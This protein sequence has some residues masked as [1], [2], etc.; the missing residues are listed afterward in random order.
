MKA[1]KKLSLV[2]VLTILSI[3]TLHAQSNMIVNSN[4][5]NGNRVLSL[6]GDGDYIEVSDSSSLHTISD[7]ITLEVW[8]KAASFYPN[9]GNVNSIIRKNLNA[10]RENFI[11]RFRTIPGGRQQIEMSPDCLSQRCENQK[12]SNWR[13]DQY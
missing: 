5:N 4:T 11:L 13:N 1:F 2:L 7:A 9:S 10:G 12:S 6:D 3:P 8:F